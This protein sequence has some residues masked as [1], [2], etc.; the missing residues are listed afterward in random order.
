M[1]DVKYI[2][3]KIPSFPHFD[4]PPSS[5]RTNQNLYCIV[6]KLLKCIDANIV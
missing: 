5:R 3:H 4:D 6:K 2:K 1:R